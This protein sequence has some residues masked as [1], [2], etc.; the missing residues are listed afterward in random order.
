M[1]KASPPDF[2]IQAMTY[3]RALIIG[4]AQRQA[5][6]EIKGQD[7]YNK[8]GFAFMRDDRKSLSQFCKDFA[9]RPKVRRKPRR[10]I[11]SHLRSESSP[12]IA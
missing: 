8:Q 12:A 11:V 3:N 4:L 1:Q 9:G 10:N 5:P 2:V 7:V 6:A